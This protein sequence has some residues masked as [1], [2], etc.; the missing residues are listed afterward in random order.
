MGRQL[1]ADAVAD[2][3]RIADSD[4][5]ADHLADVVTDGA[6]DI[7][8]NAERRTHADCNACQRR[9]QQHRQLRNEL[10]RTTLAHQDARRCVRQYDPLDADSRERF[11][12]NCGTGAGEL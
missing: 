8:T 12:V 2:G 10:R 7:N 11:D 5:E 4:A 3:K 9:R 6:A 1:D